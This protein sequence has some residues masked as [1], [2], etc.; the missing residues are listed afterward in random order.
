MKTAL[1]PSSSRYSEECVEVEFSELRPNGVP[2]KFGFL[3]SVAVMF[4]DGPLV[5]LI[6]RDVRV[7]ETPARSA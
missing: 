4:A 6:R 5:V 1:G 2:K 7:R 3:L